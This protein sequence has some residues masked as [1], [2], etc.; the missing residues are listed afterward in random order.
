[1]TGR[2]D[3]FE[4]SLCWRTRR[5]S[6][7]I[8]RR[9]RECQ[10]FRHSERDFIG[11]WRLMLPTGLL[12]TD[13]QRRGRGPSHLRSSSDW[14]KSF[15]EYI[16]QSRFFL[17]C[18]PHFGRVDWRH[19]ALRV[20]GERIGWHHAAASSSAGQ[21]RLAGRGCFVAFCSISIHFRH[22]KIVCA[23]IWQHQS[24]P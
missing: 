11:V 8:D 14:S 1:M 12:H 4:C 13:I 16:A 3:S 21:S 9:R 7:N 2:H 18:E 23:F 22:K 17:P 5:V 15:W 19:S 24:V 6:Q 20:V 10:R